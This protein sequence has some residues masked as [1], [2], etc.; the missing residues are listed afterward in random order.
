MPF[1]SDQPEDLSL[2]GPQTSAVPHF[3]HPVA[4]PGIVAP[5]NLLMPPVPRQSQSSHSSTEDCSG[6]SYEVKHKLQEHL[7][8]RHNRQSRRECATCFMTPGTLGG[9]PFLSASCAKA[10]LVPTFVVVVVVCC[11]L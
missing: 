9:K 4:P 10:L 2:R 5:S 1:A 7:I 3:N 6:C 11:L 8:Q